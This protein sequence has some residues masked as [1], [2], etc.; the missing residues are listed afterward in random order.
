MYQGTSPTAQEIISDHWSLT[1]TLI[2]AAQ[3]KDEKRSDDEI[4]GL[5]KQLEDAKHAFVQEELKL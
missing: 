2:G 1:L 3:T 5:Q 4:K